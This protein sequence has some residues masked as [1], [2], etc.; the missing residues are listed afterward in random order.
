MFQTNLNQ[1][2]SSKEQGNI[3]GRYEGR[4]TTAVTQLAP[5]SRVWSVFWL[6]WWYM[7]IHIDEWTGSIIDLFD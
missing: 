1:E 6:V 3:V 7:K 2:A 4:R 5:Q